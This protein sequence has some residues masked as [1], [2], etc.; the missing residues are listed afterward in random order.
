MPDIVN[1]FYCLMTFKK[2]N[3]N[4]FLNYFKNSK[5]LLNNVFLMQATHL[6]VKRGIHLSKSKSRKNLAICNQ[7]FQSLEGF[8]FHHNEWP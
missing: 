5:G 6:E 7:I 3:S 8:L 4:F 2:G 1:I